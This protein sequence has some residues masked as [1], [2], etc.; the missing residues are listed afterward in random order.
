MKF[1]FCLLNPLL[2]INSSSPVPAIFIWLRRNQTGFF[3][4]DNFRYFCFILTKLPSRIDTCIKNC[5]GHFRFRITVL[6]IYYFSF[7]ICNIF[8]I[9]R[10]YICQSYFII[11]PVKTPICTSYWVSAHFIPEAHISIVNYHTVFINRCRNSGIILCHTVILISVHVF[12]ES[13]KL[14]LRLVNIL[15]CIIRNFSTRNC[16]INLQIIIRRYNSAQKSHIKFILH[17]SGLPIVWKCNT[18]IIIV[19]IFYY[20]GEF[21]L[22]TLRNLYKFKTIFV[23]ILFRDMKRYL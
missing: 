8:F 12:Y 3:S 4:F 16:C 19:T 13:W 5:Y 2:Q 9:C 15:L 23:N 6:I 21:M 20:L 14:I 22:Y 1:Q 18:D 7:S 17:L 11:L 10:K